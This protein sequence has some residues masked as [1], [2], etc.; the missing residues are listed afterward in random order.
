VAE[1]EPDEGGT[2]AEAV[3]SQVLCHRRA[4]PVLDSVGDVC[5]RWDHVLDRTR[6]RVD[7]GAGQIAWEFRSLFN[8][9][10]VTTML[11]RGAPNTRQPSS[12][13]RAS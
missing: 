11:R 4:A 8:L 7:D 10:E 3:P 12:M 2:T 5:L 9:P 1:D 6:H 13:P